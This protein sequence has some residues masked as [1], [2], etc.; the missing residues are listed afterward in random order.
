MLH[1]IVILKLAPLGMSSKVLKNIF[2][3][4]IFSFISGGQ[5]AFGKK[6]KAEETRWARRYVRI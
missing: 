6:E 5:D 3:F 1:R 2:Y 4:H